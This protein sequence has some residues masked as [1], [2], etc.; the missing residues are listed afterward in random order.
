LNKNRLKGER[1][2]FIILPIICHCFK[3]KLPLQLHSKQY[4]FKGLSPQQSPPSN[5]HG[6]L[7]LI[8]SHDPSEIHSSNPPAIAAIRK[9]GKL[10]YRQ[11]WI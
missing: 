9:L 10:Q 8:S 11:I 3:K 5:W 6:T 4:C 7:L 2:I 1:P